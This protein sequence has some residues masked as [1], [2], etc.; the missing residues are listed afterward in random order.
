M[1]LQAL[2]RYYDIL[3]A[4][5]KS[6]IAPP[7]YCTTGVR[8]AL[9]LSEDGELLDIFTKSV[10]AQRGKKVVEVPQPMTVPAQ[11]KRSV[12]V[13]A[14]FMCDNSAYVL[15]LTDKASRDPDYAAKR[16]QAFRELNTSVLRA[17]D[18]EAARAV[19]AFLERHDPARARDHPAIAGQL[20]GIL[21]GGNLVFMVE[22]KLA[23][24][25]PAILQAWEAHTAKSPGPLMQ[26]LVTGEAAPM[27]R[28]HPSV[29]GVRGGQP[30]GCTLVGFNAPAY[31]SY[32]REQGGNAP[33][34]EPSVAAYTTAL[35]HLLAREDPPPITLGDS[36]VVY[37]AESTQG[38][39][40]E[41]F[42]VVFGGFDAGVA[43]REARNEAE[44]RLIKIAKKVKW[45]RGLDASALLQGLDPRTQFYVLALAPNAGRLSVR[46]FIADP[47]ERIIDRI[48]QHY[49]DLQIVKEYETQ[50][51]AISLHAI[52]GETVSQKAREPKPA[53]LLAGAVMRAILN[54]GPYPAAL[55]SAII[56]RVRADIDDPDARI[57]K[58]NYVRA[59]VVKAFLIRKVRYQSQHPFKE[60]LTVSLNEQSTIPAYVLGRLFAVLEKAQLEAIGTVG[61]SIKDRYFASA[62][63]MPASVFPVLL[64]LSQHYVSKAQYGHAIDRRIQELLNLLDVEQQPFPAH[65]SLDEQGLFILG[66]YHQ[67]AAFFAKRDGQHELA[68][69]ADE[70]IESVITEHQS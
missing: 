13:A 28:L 16:F 46:F 20:E 12:N 36:T 52:L 68:D 31:E 30:T 40:A 33:V 17:A 6:A 25:D 61:A 9:N 23:L 8:Y 3:Q 51:D 57:S 53:P 64:R 5:G 15:G 10:E 67:R 1:I 55:F 32:G 2:A 70:P 48:V 58:I 41:W 7:G 29:R 11:V 4:E 42:A 35:N 47:F 19:I 45:A 26:C 38:D 49:R 18:S 62:C 24:K 69:L 54:G 22:R 34:G 56:T 27:A 66:Y 14:N 39:Y 50:P 63:A 37:W 65:L 21:K 43:A 44:E 59:A 60:V